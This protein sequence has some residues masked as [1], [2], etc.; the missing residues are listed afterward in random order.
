MQETY[1]IRRQAFLTSLD[2]IDSSR[3]SPEF[4]QEIN[5]VRQAL[6]DNLTAETIKQ[7]MAVVQKNDELN[8]LYDAERLNLKEASNEQQRNNPKGFIDEEDKPKPQDI[9]PGNINPPSPEKPK[10]D[11]PPSQPPSQ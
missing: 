10:N 8:Q 11:N 6:N 2:K 5:T 9:A 4:L 1:V 7:L 3:F